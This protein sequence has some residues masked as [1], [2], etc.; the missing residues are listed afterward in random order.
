MPGRRPS[1]RGAPQR[2]ATRRRHALRTIAGHLTTTAPPRPLAPRTVVAAAEEH[3]ELPPAA[4]ATAEDY[5]VGEGFLSWHQ[6][7]TVRNGSLAA[8]WVC[9]GGSPERDVLSYVRQ[10][11]KGEDELVVVDV[12]SKKKKGAVQ[13]FGAAQ[14]ATMLAAAGAQLEDVGAFKLGALKML[15]PA[16]LLLRH[17]GSPFSVDLAAGTA[18]PLPADGVGKSEV[19][20]PNGELVL[21]A[22]GDNLHLRAVAEPVGGASRALTMDGEEHFSYG[23]PT[24]ATHVSLA[25]KSGGPQ[26]PRPAAIWSPDSAKVLTSRVDERAIEEYHLIQSAPEDGSIRPKLWSYK[27]ALPGDPV[28]PATLL[29]I[30]VGTGNV[31]EIDVSA[32]FGDEHDAGKRHPAL[33]LSAVCVRLDPECS[34]RTARG[35]DVA[36][37]RCDWMVDAVEGSP[38]AQDMAWWSPD[39]STVRF[40]GASSQHSRFASP[41]SVAPSSIV[42]LLVSPDFD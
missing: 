7:K 37:S 22:A 29:V 19:P 9:D 20:S 36:E 12:S 32:I 14:V 11:P 21:F 33:L 24:G 23:G 18:A 4:P 25:R 13:V 16:S 1:R 42:R 5:A 8:R 30:E 38:V 34:C 39:S 17:G 27:Y 3:D 15:S 35:T 10:S 41:S 31:V 2:S 28:P 26:A 6:E 40:I